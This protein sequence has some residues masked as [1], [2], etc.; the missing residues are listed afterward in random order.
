ML[1]AGVTGVGAKACGWPRVCCQAV[2]SSHARSDIA[3]ELLVP[4]VA[5]VAPTVSRRRGSGLPLLLVSMASAAPPSDL[6]SG[7]ANCATWQP[8]KA[9]TH[10]NTHEYARVLHAD[11]RPRRTI[12]LLHGAK[13]AV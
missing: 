4:I 8:H 2:P 6:H 11:E 5:A 1:A 3:T 9:P 12:A 7:S 13:A 10:M